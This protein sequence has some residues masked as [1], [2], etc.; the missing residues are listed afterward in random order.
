VIKAGIFTLMSNRCFRNDWVPHPTKTKGS[1]IKGK[2][3]GILI[4]ILIGRNYKA[5][6]HHGQE[7]PI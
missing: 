7:R 3:L 6:M 1:A 2:D 4:N 5:R